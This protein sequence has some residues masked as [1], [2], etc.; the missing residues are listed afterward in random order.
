MLRLILILESKSMKIN[1]KRGK[2]EWQKEKVQSEKA[3]VKR[4]KGQVKSKKSKERN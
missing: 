1:P 2:R 3:K 4:Y